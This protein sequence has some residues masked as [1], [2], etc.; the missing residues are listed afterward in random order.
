MCK[1]FGHR[2]VLLSGGMCVQILVI[3]HGTTTD[4]A[5]G[6][7]V[8][9]RFTLLGRSICSWHRFSP[10]TAWFGSLYLCSGGNDHTRNYPGSTTLQTDLVQDILW[11]QAFMFI[12][13]PNGVKEEEVSNTPL[14]SQQ[15]LLKARNLPGSDG[16]PCI[17]YL[18]VAVVSGTLLRGANNVLTPKSG[19]AQGK[20]TL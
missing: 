15:Q 2:N 11:T 9:Y 6:V 12:K 8:C 5:K 7:G 4:H 18:F 20:V 3:H 19:Q 10:S 14:R 17:C 1:L 16:P 13:P